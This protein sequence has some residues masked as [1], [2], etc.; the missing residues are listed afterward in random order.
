MTTVQ[1]RLVAIKN[2]LTE[3][4]CDLVVD[5]IKSNDEEKWRNTIEEIDSARD[6][7][8]N[9]IKIAEMEG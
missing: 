1:E 9:A 8:W 3:L 6:Y 2:E 4:K 5:S 7:I